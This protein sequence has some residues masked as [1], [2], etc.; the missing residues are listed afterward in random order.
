MQSYP[1][2]GPQSHRVTFIA[3]RGPCHPKHN[4][5]PQPGLEVYGRLV[6]EVWVPPPILNFN[7]HPKRFCSGWFVDLTLRCSGT[8]STRA[9]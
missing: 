7:R 5:E 2:L 9:S 4:T 3:E 6:E 8:Y 1:Y